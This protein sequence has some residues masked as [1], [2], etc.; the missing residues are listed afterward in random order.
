MFDPIVV[1][2]VGVGEFRI[3]TLSSKL[4]GDLQKAISSYGEDPEKL[5][6]EE[7]AGVL[8]KMLPGITKEQAEEIDIRHVVRI[9]TFLAEQINT[10]NEASTAK[11]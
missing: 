1:E 7:I 5:K 10:A 2:L 6:S 9:A 4:L 11:N 8:M 3:E